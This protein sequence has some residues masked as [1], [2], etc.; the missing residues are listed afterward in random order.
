MKRKNRFKATGVI[1][2]L[3][4][5]M[6]ICIIAIKKKKAELSK[7]HPVDKNPIPVSIV[8]LRK[9]EFTFFKQYVGIITPLN[10]SEISSRIT[11]EI[12]EIKVTEGS[13]VKKGD[14]LIRLD[15]RAL[16]QSIKVLKAKLE[17]M[18]TQILAN[19]VKIES[20]KTSVSYWEKQ[21]SRDKKLFDDNIVSAKAYELSNEKLNRIKGEYKIAMQQ[22]NTYQATLN[23]ITEDVKIAET[24][25]SYAV[26]AAPFDGVICNVPVDPGVLAIPGKGLVLIENQK[27][28]KVTVLIPQ[29]DMKDIY[30]KQSLLIAT[31][32]NNKIN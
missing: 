29:I 24:N 31:D 32:S 5:I 11:A 2:F 23:S 15:D 26:I 10:S 4:I 20:L 21:V 14:V 13:N 8:E 7:A 22:N 6:I 27:L 17:G 28:L 1:I 18:K 16:K 3:V 19:K 25:L 30:L 9:G 12:I